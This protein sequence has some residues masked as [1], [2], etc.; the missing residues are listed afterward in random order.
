M[1]IF[2]NKKHI[3]ID[4]GASEIKII[5]GKATKKN[6]VIQNAYT[7]KIPK[8]LYSDGMIL[9]MDQLSYLL[10]T[11]LKDNKI[12]SNMA[13]V[14][15]NSSNIIT[16]EIS[17]PKVSDGEIE[18]ILKYQA[19]DFIPI[20]PQ[21]YIFQYIHLGRVFD[22]GVEKLN[23]LLLA[24]PKTIIESHLNLINNIGLKPKVMDFQGHAIGKLFNYNDMFNETNLIK[25][26]AIASVDMGY[27]NTKV[28]IILNGVLKVSRVVNTGFS[29]LIKDIQKKVDRNEEEILDII[30]DIDLLEEVNFL[31][32]ENT[33]VIDSINEVLS[34][35][36]DGIDMV[37]KYYNTRDRDNEIDYIILQGGLSNI[38]GLETR[39]KRFFNINAIKL[40]SFDR[41]KSDEDM[42][43]YSNAVAGL[44]RLD[45]VQR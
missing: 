36:F 41:I 14:V 35:V 18:S 13:T 6:I 45:E 40:H 12:M 21:D 29:H 1:R 2:D 31:D 32:S 19:E 16:R 8:N 4:I 26:K 23:L 44:I 24:I 37:I 30:K 22:D 9:S 43:A 27:D 17:L 25:G 28:N 7:L 10:K 39:F 38:H 5:E 3:S 34:I 15:V 33:F 11:S 20:E 42:G